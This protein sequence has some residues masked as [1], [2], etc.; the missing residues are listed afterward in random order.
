MGQDNSN[1]PKRPATHRIIDSQTGAIVGRGTLHRCHTRAD[2]LDLEYGA[3]RYTVRRATPLELS[4]DELITARTE[5][6]D[7]QIREG[8][9]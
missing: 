4:Q 1:K 2:A 7:K 8:R 5:W 9:K 3:V 6:L